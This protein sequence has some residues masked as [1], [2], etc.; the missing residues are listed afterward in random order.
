HVIECKAIGLRICEIVVIIRIQP[1]TV[2][3]THR[4]GG[5]GSGTC[6]YGTDAARWTEHRQFIA[7]GKFS[8]ETETIMYI[9]DTTI[10]RI[11]R[12]P[13]MFKFDNALVILFP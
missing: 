9:D 12:I 11:F 7:V 4:I 6:M 1:L 8:I 13:L 5:Y 2:P 10:G 3:D